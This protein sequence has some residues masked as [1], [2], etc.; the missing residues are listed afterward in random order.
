[1]VEQ[2]GSGIG[3]MKLAMKEADLPEPE[4][5][6]DGIFTVVFRRSLSSGKSS[7]KISVKG[8]VKGLITSM[9][10][11]DMFFKE[12][13]ARVLGDNEKEILRRIVLNPSILLSF[14]G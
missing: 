4:F 7:G 12:L 3:R 5:K 1:M 11:L 9:E 8:D 10:G 6:T 13:S 2:I 14:F